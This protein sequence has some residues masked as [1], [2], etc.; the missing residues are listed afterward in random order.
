MHDASLLTHSFTGPLGWMPGPILSVWYYTAVVHNAFLVRNYEARKE[1]VEKN[2]A[3]EIKISEEFK[4]ATSL[5]FNVTKFGVYYLY[6]YLWRLS[7]FY[8]HSHRR[9]TVRVLLL[10]LE[11]EFPE[12]KLLLSEITTTLES[13]FAIPK[14]ETV[15]LCMAM[16]AEEHISQFEWLILHIV[17]GRL[18][19]QSRITIV[20]S[21]VCFTYCHQSLIS[22]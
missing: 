1:R 2:L 10:T 17:K 18:A 14:D 8:L 7:Y 5:L 6:S 16:R 3:H 4:N 12:T 20:P 13:V 15:H 9:G 11:E 22:K 21:I 19:S